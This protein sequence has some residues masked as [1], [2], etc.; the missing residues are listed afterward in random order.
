M[1]KGRELIRLSDKNNNVK[2]CLE[3]CRTIEHARACEWSVS[4][5][6]GEKECYAHKMRV[7][8]GSG[9]AHSD[10]KCWVFSG[11]LDI[12]IVKHHFFY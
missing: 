4:F 1:T 5:K 11:R 6:D 12:N 10:A 9:S 2:K 3:H 8:K 7:N